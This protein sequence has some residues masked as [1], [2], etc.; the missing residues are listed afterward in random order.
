VCRFEVELLSEVPMAF[1]ATTDSYKSKLFI[2]LQSDKL[3]VVDELNGYD[4]DQFLGEL[5]GAWGLFLGA[6]LVNVVAL[7]YAGCNTAVS[8]YS[9][10]KVL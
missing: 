1:N 2:G 8:Y 4:I 5:G 3:R 10:R 7:L 9:D 6:S